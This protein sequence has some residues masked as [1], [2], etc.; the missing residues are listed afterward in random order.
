M[1]IADCGMGFPNLP[2]LVRDFHADAD[3]AM[4]GR[5]EEE[6]NCG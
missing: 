4:A 6:Q 1:R 5:V 2:Q 3:P